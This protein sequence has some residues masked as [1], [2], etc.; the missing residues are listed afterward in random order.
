MPNLSDFVHIPPIAG[1]SIGEGATKWR[2]I[3]K[4]ATR[5]LETVDV[6]SFE[7]CSDPI[8]AGCGR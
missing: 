5:A 8:Y 6:V 2:R 3:M 1:F 7:E 4:V